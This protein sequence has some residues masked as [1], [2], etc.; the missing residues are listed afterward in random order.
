MA[1]G[2]AHR[3]RLIVEYDGTAYAGWQRQ[4]NALAVQQVLEEHLC[5]LTGEDIRVTGSSRTDAGVHA[6]AQNVHFDT[7]TRIPSEKISFALNTTLP[8][9]IRVRASM[10]AAADFHA[11]YRATGK[12]YRYAIHNARHEG[13]LGRYTQAHVALALD[14]AR[15]QREA[16]AMIGHHDFAAFAAAGSIVK[17][18]RRTVYNVRVTREAERVEMY[19]HGDG[20]LYNMVRIL[21]GTLIEVGTGKR[22]AGAIEKALCSHSRLDLGM[23]APAKGLTLMDV[24]YGDDERAQDY[25]RAKP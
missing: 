1:H 24:F 19:V 5:R 2:E 12:V 13:A 3:V 9:D 7:C 14:I 11:R 22:A 16:E 8:R 15:M 25:F 18:T 4:E 17:D 23:T 6:L 21:A 10:D 20:F